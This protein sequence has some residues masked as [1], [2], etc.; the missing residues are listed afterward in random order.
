[1]KLIF[2]TGSRFGRFNYK[3]A[4]SIVD[5]AISNDI[6]AFDTAYH[7]GNNKSQPLL[8]ECLKKHFKKGREE[9]IISTK[10][11]P[12]SAEYI[13]FCVEESLEVFKSDYL[14]YF[15]LWGAGANHL[16]SPEIVSC[17]RS[18]IKSGKI[19][20][21]CVT[22]QDLRTIKKISTGFYEEISCILL[23]LSLIHI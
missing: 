17:L 23:D 1:M 15:H 19:R 8:A 11:F 4:S 9:F 18:L 22:S 3:N 16:E 12:K 5:F 14:D 13:K 20:N 2:G 6:K 21:A 10:C 7:Y